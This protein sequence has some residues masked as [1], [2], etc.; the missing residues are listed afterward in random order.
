MRRHTSEQPR[1]RNIGDRREDQRRYKIGAGKEGN[2][3][4]KIAFGKGDEREAVA[5]ITVSVIPNSSRI[6]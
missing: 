2:E 6:P 5:D 1:S 3:A 4:N